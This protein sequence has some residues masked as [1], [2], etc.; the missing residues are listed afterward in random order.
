MEAQNTTEYLSEALR[1]GKVASVRA[2]MSNLHAGEIANLLEA[3][4]IP[5]RRIVWKLTDVALEGDILLEVSEEVRKNLI[6]LTQDEELLLATEGLEIDDLADLIDTLPDTVTRQLLTG[7]D[8]QNRHRLEQVLSYDADTAGGLMNPDVFTLRANIT[9]DVAI[10]YIKMKKTLPQH[11]DNL[12]VV[13]HTNHYSGI[14]A[15]ADLITCDN[16]TLLSNLVNTEITAIPVS[17]S[18]NEVVALF[19][20]RD[21]VSVA[22]VDADNKVVGRVTVDD[23]LDV[24]RDEPRQE[25]IGFSGASGEEDLYAPVFSAAR[26]RALWLGV[27][28]LTAFIAAWFISLFED[29]LQQIIILAILVPVVSSMGGIA[30]SQSLMITIRALATKRLT[31]DN[32]SMLLIKEALVGS[33]NGFFWAIIVAAITIL[34][35][36][37]I[38][39]GIII[40]AAIVANLVCAAGVGVMIPILL[41][42]LGI[43]PALAGSV[44]LT[45]ITDIVGVVAFLG[46]AT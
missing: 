14:V 11:T 24:L 5:E 31:E 39:I 22:V 36:G 20:D 12:I 13:D 16:D 18:A 35:I 9:A 23:V 38:K 7:M 8:A 32:P 4:P 44:V 41:K 28:L 1:S 6:E 30:G 29:T 34:W 33:L 25:R 10:R 42:K 45:T 15:I 40:A 3:L 21:W 43:D 27:N 19:E 46:L 2:L 17:M 26:K 37:D